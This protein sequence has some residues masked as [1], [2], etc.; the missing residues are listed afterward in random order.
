MNNEAG[1]NQVEVE[2]QICDNCGQKI[3]KSRFRLHYMGCLRQNRV[4]QPSPPKKLEESKE[5]PKPEI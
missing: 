4:K 5:D 2:Y 1:D 3:E